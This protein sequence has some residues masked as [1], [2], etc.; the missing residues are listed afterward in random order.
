MILYDVS[1]LH[2]I[3]T[4]TNNG[5]STCEI[6]NAFRSKIIRS[7]AGVAA[8]MGTKL[9]FIFFKPLFILEGMSSVSAI[10]APYYHP[11]AET[12]LAYHAELV[13]LTIALGN[14]L[15]A[16]PAG[17]V[18]GCI[19]LGNIGEGLVTSQHYGISCYFIELQVMQQ[20][21]IGS[22]YP[23]HEVLG[24]ECRCFVHEADCCDD[25]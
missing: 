4:N 24:N 16:P 5:L 20:L 17:D 10:L 9:F 21:D 14:G 15:L 23:V 1:D 18:I 22:E 25:C 7:I 2:H 12:A 11:L 13:A 19:A 8:S 3:Y 6:G